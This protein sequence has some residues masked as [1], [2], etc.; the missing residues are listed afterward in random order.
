VAQQAGGPEL[1]GGPGAGDVAQSAG[2]SID[3]TQPGAITTDSLGQKL[4]YGIPVN[5]KGSFIPP[6]PN[7]PADELAKQTAAYN[8]W[9]ADFMKR[10]PD[11][12]QMP[13]G[14]MQGI[15]PGLAP[16]YPSN[17]TP[18]MDTGGLTP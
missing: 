12:T 6:N 4:E 7:L 16:M 17:Y 9:K 10:W 1:L 18:G 8:A 14:S 2:A 11:A 13:D 15:K 3:Y 5:N